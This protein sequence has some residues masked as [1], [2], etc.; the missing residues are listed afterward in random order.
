MTISVVYDWMY[1]NY[2]WYIDL[3]G[4]ISYDSSGKIDSEIDL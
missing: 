3:D 2:G 4:E 1:Y